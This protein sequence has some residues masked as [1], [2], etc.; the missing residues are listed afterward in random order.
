MKF[1]N[2]LITP[3]IPVWTGTEFI[4]PVDGI[5]TFE[6]NLHIRPYSTNNKRFRIN[7]RVNGNSVDY[8]QDNT[9]IKSTGTDPASSSHYQII[10][11]MKSGQKLDFFDDYYGSTQIYDYTSKSCYTNGKS[12]RCS[13][14][15]GRLMRKL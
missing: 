13:W 2:I 1:E 8:I 5:Y 6:M 12:H 10:Q 3:S 9:S 4:A 7:V 15:S 14:I 11:E